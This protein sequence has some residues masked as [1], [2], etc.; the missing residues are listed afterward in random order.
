MFYVNG[1]PAVKLHCNQT[2]L[3][4]FTL[5]HSQVV[6]WYFVTTTYLLVLQ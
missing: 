4:V 6:N 5:F 1:Q 2:K 3:K